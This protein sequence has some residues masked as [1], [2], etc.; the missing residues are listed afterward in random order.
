M[1][2]I[3]HPLQCLYCQAEFMPVGRQKYCTRTCSRKAT[4]KY[5]ICPDCGAR[6][7]CYRSERCRS[8][9]HAEDRRWK[10]STEVEL[11]VAPPRKARQWP[12]P[13]R[14]DP[15][16][17]RTGP[18]AICG[19][20]YT[21][22]YVSRTCSEECKRALHRDTRKRAKHN[23]RA[24]IKAAF[25]APVEPRII[26]RRDNWTCQICMDPIDPSEVW[27]SPMCASLDHIVP[28]AHGGTHEPSNCQAAH[29]I[30]NALKSD[31]LP[32]AV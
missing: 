31:T 25:V 17:F 10:G 22:T 5:S 32:S 8:C 4:R 23:R 20:T 24:A 6:T 14:R 29:F 27:P 11:W 21:T 3:R 28:I 30:C 7:G 19:E 2:I 9:Q 13:P 1:V 26:F 12:K 15:R 16:T 18:C